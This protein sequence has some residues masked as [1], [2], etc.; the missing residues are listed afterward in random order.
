VDSFLRP[1]GGIYGRFNIPAVCC[2]ILGTL[3]QLPFVSTPLYRGPIARALHDA[4]LSWL[5]GLVV[6]S[7]AYY[8][9]ARPV[10]YSA[11]NSIRPPY[12]K[13]T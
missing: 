12:P 7:V 9:L 4:D 13:Q 3:V 5:V 10:T 6:T 11:P 2:Y 1:D 8:A